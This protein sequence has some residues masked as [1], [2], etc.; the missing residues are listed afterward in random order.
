[1]SMRPCV[2]QPY[3]FNCLEGVLLLLVLI[4]LYCI[5]SI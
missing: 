3:L 1:M 5:F 2:Q 4:H